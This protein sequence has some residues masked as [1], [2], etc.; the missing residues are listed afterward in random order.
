AMRRSPA[1][2]VPAL[3]LVAAAARADD[4]TIRQRTTISGDGRSETREEMQYAHDDL[5]VIDAPDTRT[6]VDVAAKTMTV[7]DKQKRTYFV[8]SFDD[9]RR[10]AEAVQERARRMPPDVRKMLD[11][12]LG[13]GAPITLVPTGKRE[14]IAGYPATEQALSGG[15]FRGAIWTT[16]AIAPPAGV[17]KWRELS[18]S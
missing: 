7:A 14:T 8:M 3:L 11:E 4:L 10:Q 9:M 6:I 12:M 16:D 2:L 18:A 5:L 1:A 17:R 13:N 15:P